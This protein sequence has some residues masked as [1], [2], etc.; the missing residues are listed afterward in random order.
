MNRA[1]D[2]ADWECPINHAQCWLATVNGEYNET[3]LEHV[4]ALLNESSLQYRWER[5]KLDVSEWWLANRFP[6]AMVLVIAI[7]LGVAMKVASDIGAER[8]GT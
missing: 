3:D 5:L 1:P 8:M 7:V 4:Q 2:H 6:L